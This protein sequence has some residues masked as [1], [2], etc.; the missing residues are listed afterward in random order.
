[1]KTII[2][3]TDFS[4][5]AENAVDYAAALIQQIGGKIVLFNLYV[6]SIHVSNARLS[7]QAFDQS[8]NRTKERLASRAAALSDAYAIPVLS[9]LSVMGD[10]GEEIE[11]LF[12]TYDASLL[13][14][15]MAAK[16]LEQDLLGNTTTALIHQFKFPVLAVPYGAKFK[17]VDRILFA[18]DNLQGVHQVI[19]QEVKTLALGMKASV[20]IFH[21]NNQI[22]RIQD[23]G[24]DDQTIAAFGEGLEG[25]TYYY[26]DV[27]SNAVIKAIQNE[28]INI[29]ADLLIMLPNKYGFW[30]SLI[31]RSK[32]RIMASGLSIALLSIP[33]TLASRKERTDA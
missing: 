29:N 12:A 20:E 5:E 2:V 31:H 14:M 32:T 10:M 1:M 9:Y 3:A 25:V 24:I 33:L 11:H 8:A 4:K 26:K 27:A 6:P 21:V 30:G 7:P 13:V 17:G 16:S 28:L 18:C 23:E 19:L 22:R 15:G